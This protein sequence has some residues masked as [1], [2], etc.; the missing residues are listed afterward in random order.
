MVLVVVEALPAGN[1]PP[2]AVGERISEGERHDLGAAAPLPTRA[3]SLEQDRAED[4]MESSP[5]LVKR[6]G[7]GS[8]RFTEKLSPCIA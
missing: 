8:T 6:F 2:V 7:S 3:S 5:K 4:P 1:K